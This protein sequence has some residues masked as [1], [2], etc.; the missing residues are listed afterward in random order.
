L[1]LK[2]GGKAIDD[3]WLSDRLSSFNIRP[4]KEPITIDSNRRRGYYKSEFLK[5]WSVY[6]PPLHPETA[7]SGVT[8]VLSVKEHPSPTFEERV[9]AAQEL[10]AK[11]NAELEALMQKAR[12][13]QL[14]LS[15]LSS[16]SSV[17]S[18]SGV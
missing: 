17:T 1:Y 18:V 7:V 13:P 8:S 14:P 2:K 6:L 10:A 15:A 11:R 4:D 9:L 3:R 12:R 5:A 16:V